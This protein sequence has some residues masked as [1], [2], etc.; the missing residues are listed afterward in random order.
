GL[1]K[2][3]NA[4]ESAVGAIAPAVIRAGEDCGTALV[5]AAY[6]HAA[7]AAGVEEHM[8]GAGTVAAEDHR[9]LAHAGD[10]EIAWLRDLALVADEEPGAGEDPL[11]FLP[12]DRLV[13]EDF[14]ADPSRRE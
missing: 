11:L 12:I 9:F 5:V 6:L 4:D 13:D 7:M 14:A 10:E 3:R 8:D 2:L 1:A